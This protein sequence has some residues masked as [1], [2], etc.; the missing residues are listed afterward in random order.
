MK[1]TISKMPSHE[2]SLPNQTQTK[3]GFGFHSAGRRHSRGTEQQ[4]QAVSG[5][6]LEATCI[7]FILLFFWTLVRQTLAPGRPPLKAVRV[8]Q[9][10]DE[11][12]QTWLIH[13]SRCTYMAINPAGGQ[14]LTLMTD[15]I[16][17]PSVQ[18]LRKPEPVRVLHDSLLTKKKKT[19]SL[20]SFSFLQIKA[21]R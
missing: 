13:I 12:A 16:T 11:Y 5:H 1:W 21:Q 18:Q 14:D 6:R 8:Q 7:K 4:R 3:V 15:V 19:F 9:N 10:K 17:G 2:R 20:C